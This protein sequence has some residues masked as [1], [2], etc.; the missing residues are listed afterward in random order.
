MSNSD[1]SFFVSESVKLAREMNLPD[2]RRYLRGLLE[3][4][5]DSPEVEDVRHAA[6]L[7][8]QSD[9]QL[10]LIISSKAVR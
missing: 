8:D 9:R 4:A 6:V 1:Q 5:G 10:E 3:I 7:L 2:A